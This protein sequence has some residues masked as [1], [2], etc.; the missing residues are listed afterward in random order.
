MKK[1][2]RMKN[3]MATAEINITYST[4]IGKEKRIV[5]EKEKI[6]DREYI[7]YDFMKKATREV[8]SSIIDSQYKEG[9]NLSIRF[10]E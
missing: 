7:S 4:G 5:R 9:R 2:K 1:R 8:L 10:S 6:E 3:K